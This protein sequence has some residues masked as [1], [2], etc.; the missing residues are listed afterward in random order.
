MFEG[1]R[2]SQRTTLKA[3][4]TRRVAA[5]RVNIRSTLTNAGSFQ[6]KFIGHHI[7]KND[8]KSAL[9]DSVSCS[10]T[11]VSSM[12]AGVGLPRL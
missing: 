2:I 9:V 11:R 7:G 12:A 8:L 6:G 4:Q 5:H 10:G 3:F 1:E